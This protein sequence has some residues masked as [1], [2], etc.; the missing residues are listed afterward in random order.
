MHWRIEKYYL[1]NRMNLKVDDTQ[2]IA[3]IF[4]KSIN[5]SWMNDHSS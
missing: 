5:I 4:L 2:E 1:A 3:I